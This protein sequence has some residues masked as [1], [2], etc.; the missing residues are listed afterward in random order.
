MSIC[1]K[2][3][4]WIDFVTIDGRVVPLHASGGCNGEVIKKIATTFKHELIHSYSYYV[5]P[6]ARCPVCARPV[7]YYENNNGSRVYFD[8]L[9]PPWPKHLC[10][11]N[12]FKANN[13]EFSKKGEEKYKKYEVTIG[14]W[15]SFP[16]Y[17]ITLL[18]E[19]RSLYYSINGY[20]MNKYFSIII[21][22][23]KKIKLNNKSPFF[24]RKIDSNVYEISTIIEMEEIYIYKCIGFVDIIK[25][26]GSRSKIKKP[27]EFN[28]LNHPKS[29]F[30]LKRNLKKH[31]DYFTNKKEHPVLDEYECKKCGRPVFKFLDHH[32]NEH[33]LEKVIFPWT[34]HK[35]KRDIMNTPSNNY[36]IAS[37]LE[38][39][40][41]N[42]DYI[43]LKLQ[44]NFNDS[45]KIRLKQPFF[46]INRTMPLSINLSSEGNIATLATFIVVCG[47]II[48]Q[49]LKCEVLV[50]FTKY[51]FHS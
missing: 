44:V 25:A 33:Y 26:L 51:N 17:S 4:D 38:I 15:N 24:I 3:G 9:G 29:E 46:R 30:S 13:S 35:C 47:K 11:D 8:S 1:R 19:Y 49:N 7:F 32:R 48:P 39:K 45:Y 42:D 16:I 34:R 43:T 20:F 50:E 21:T 41:S 31:E 5:N 14:N 40:K 37:L 12:K 18:D 23:S 2:C 6:H 10:T 22:P 36:I 27:D 28:I